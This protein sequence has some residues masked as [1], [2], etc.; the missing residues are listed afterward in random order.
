[1]K[2]WQYV[3]FYWMWIGFSPDGHAQSRI[4][5]DAQDATELFFKSL[6]EEDV[7]ALDQLLAADFE[8]ID[9][10]GKRM[11]KELVLTWV[12]QGYLKINDS[13]VAQIRV[14]TYSEI[15]LANG[16]WNVSL[17]FQGARIQGDVYFGAIYQKV[18]GLRKLISLQLTPLP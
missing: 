8:M 11:N 13:Y 6:Q 12:E 10:Q 2:A 17:K 5:R 4:P 7:S 16:N 1:M 18:G 14:K 15:E 3:L 9:F